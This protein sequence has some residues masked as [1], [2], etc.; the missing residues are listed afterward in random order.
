MKKI[1][2]PSGRLVITGTGKVEAVSKSQQRRLEI[3]MQEKEPQEQVSLPPIPESAVELGKPS[4]NSSDQDQEKRNLG[5][6][7]EAEGAQEIPAQ[8]D[9]QGP[10]DQSEDLKALKIMLENAHS[11]Y[12]KDWDEAINKGE[13]DKNFAEMVSKPIPIDMDRVTTDPNPTPADPVK[14]FYGQ[15]QNGLVDLEKE[16]GVSSVVSPNGDSLTESVDGAKFV[17]IPDTALDGII[18]LGKGKNEF[19]HDSVQNALKDEAIEGGIVPYKSAA[20]M[21]SDDP[22]KD[23]SQ[24]KQSSIKESEGY[25]LY[26]FTIQYTDGGRSVTVD[27]NDFFDELEIATVSING[28]KYLMPIHDGF[29]LVNIVSGIPMISHQD[30]A[31]YKHVNNAWKKI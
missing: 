16:G 5:M 24:I 29:R 27:V 14:E 13:E 2:L 20:A 11:F 30:Q 18:D 7:G 17:K 1:V 3:Q 23:G 6:L 26:G 22:A 12:N 25:K 28:N 4:V 10:N 21:R 9:D 15:I 8:S 31:I 19:S